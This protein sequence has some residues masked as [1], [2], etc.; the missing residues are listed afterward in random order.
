MLK[1]LGHLRVDQF[2]R[3]P[4]KFVSLV[5]HARLDV[6]LPPPPPP[7]GAA[8]TTSAGSD[9]YHEAIARRAELALLLDALLATSAAAGAA[10]WRELSLN[11][12]SQVLEPAMHALLR[13]RID[14]D[15]D[16]VEMLC[17]PPPAHPAGGRRRGNLVAAT[18]AGS[19][20]QAAAAPPPHLQHH[21][22]GARASSDAAA[23]H[24]ASLVE[25]LP[26]QAICELDVA[27]AALGLHAHFT[28]DLTLDAQ[29]QLANEIINHYLSPETALAL[30]ASGGCGGGGGGNDGNNSNPVDRGDGDGGGGGGG[31]GG[32]G[33]CWLG[34]ARV[35]GVPVHFEAFFTAAPFCAKG[36]GGGGGSGG[37]G[38][39]VA[40][41]D[42]GTVAVGGAHG[43]LF[44]D[45]LTASALSQSHTP[46]YMKASHGVGKRAR[47]QSML[48]LPS[49]GV[50]GF[51]LFP[52]DAYHVLTEA[53]DYD[54]K[55]PR[56]AAAASH[57]HRRVLTRL[58][59]VGLA[60]R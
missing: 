38:G 11:G 17:G 27:D 21:E 50:L 15:T 24:V 31:D 39:G 49:A 56:D 32:G 9:A 54:L 60:L 6:S 45:D 10:R 16:S 8:E 30:A 41:D 19:A 1:A 33:G 18:E 20:A 57:M 5:V 29:R 14:D 53:H 2:L 51:D 7:G 36:E 13:Q 44:E 26:A 23:H 12:S 25:S 46:S 52:Q 59:E 35:N 58:G 55:A 4:A 22:Y 40:H 43:S 3:P 42:A 48:Y 37:N 47:P 34:N 28:F